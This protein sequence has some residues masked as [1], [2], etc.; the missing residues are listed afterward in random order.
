M[1]GT[2]TKKPGNPKRLTGKSSAGEALRRC[3]ATSEAALKRLDPKEDGLDV[4]TVHRF[5]TTIRRL[6]SLLS[7]FTELLPP[8][9]RKALAER[10]KVMAQRYAALRELDVL[11][12]VLDE[13]TSASERRKLADVSEAAKRRRQAAARRGASLVVDIRAVERAIATAKWLRAPSP[14]EIHAWNQSI[15]EYAADLLDSQRRKMRRGSRNLN[16]SD[17]RSLH[18]FRIATK[19]HRYTIEF[20][21]PLYGKR[22]TRDYLARLV[23]VQDVLGDLRDASTAKDLVATLRLPPASRLIAARWLER[24]G[25]LCHKRFPA[26]HAAFRRE[27]PFWEH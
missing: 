10:L 21:T 16:L 11:I 19:K 26:C 4:E 5:R 23:A 1:A 25:A 20:L 14:G 15:G 9:E 3:I 17:L 6:R 18:K 7:A 27:T 22:K 13:E 8:K 24:R 2:A 12:R